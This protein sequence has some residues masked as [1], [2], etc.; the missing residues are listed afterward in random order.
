MHKKFI[1]RSKA[2]NEYANNTHGDILALKIHIF[3]KI[4]RKNHC[5]FLYI[6]AT[7]HTKI[8]KKTKIH[9]LL[10]RILLKIPLKESLSFS[11]GSRKDR[12]LIQLANSNK[13][14]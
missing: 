11:K 14:K 3:L 12:C 7:H 10:H 4:P 9:A 8:K 13:D 2:V 6:L 1:S 5:S